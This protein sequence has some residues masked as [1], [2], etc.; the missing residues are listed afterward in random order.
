MEFVILY[1]GLVLCGVMTGLALLVYEKLFEQVE[2]KHD[3]RNATDV[4][5][6]VGSDFERI[7]TEHGDKSSSWDHDDQLLLM[8]SIQVQTP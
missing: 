2:I 5:R 8:C 4:M 1:A 7:L 6:R 3:G